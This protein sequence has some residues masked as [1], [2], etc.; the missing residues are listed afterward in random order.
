MDLLA[1]EEPHFESTLRPW[2]DVQVPPHRR[3]FP[4]ISKKADLGCALLFYSQLP[5]SS[6][7]THPGCSPT[8]IYSLSV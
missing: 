6:L 1:R 8:F 3:S 5:S 7:R 2:L 4:R